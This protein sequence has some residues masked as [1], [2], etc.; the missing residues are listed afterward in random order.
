MSFLYVHS[1]LFIIVCRMCEKVFFSFL[2]SFVLFI[3]C[4]LLNVLQCGFELLDIVIGRYIN[5]WLHVVGIIQCGK[6]FDSTAN[7]YSLNISESQIQYWH[8]YSI[9]PSSILYNKYYCMHN[10][11]VIM[12]WFLLFNWNNTL[13]AT[14]TCTV[15]WKNTFLFTYVTNRICAT[16]ISLDSHLMLFDCIFSQVRHYYSNIK[17]VCCSSIQESSNRVL[18]PSKYFK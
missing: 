10:N 8:S 3:D 17:I 1:I 2:F 7:K 12:M 18:N 14:I 11:P 4:V 15:N 6:S 5:K 9:D 13:L 16:I